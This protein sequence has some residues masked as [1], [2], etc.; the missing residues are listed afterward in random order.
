M[1]FIWMALLQARN[2]KVLEVFPSESTLLEPKLF[3][4]LHRRV[5]V[6]KMNRFQKSR[7]NSQTRAEGEK[8]RDVC[9]AKA[10]HEDWEENRG[11]LM[12]SCQGTTFKHTLTNFHSIL[13]FTGFFPPRNTSRAFSGKPSPYPPHSEIYCIILHQPRGLAKISKRSGTT[14][15]NPRGWRQHWRFSPHRSESCGVSVFTWKLF[16]DPAL[17]GQ[18]LLWFCLICC[19]WQLQARESVLSPIWIVKFNTT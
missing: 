8:I 6:K 4:R 14:S 5:T 10:T 9:S 11:T 7:T 3:C 13:I 1:G 19:L 18:A 16:A 2:S 15:E 12:G 17:T